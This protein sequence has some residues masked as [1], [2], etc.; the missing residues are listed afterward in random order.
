M[1]STTTAK[2]KA[3]MTE[4]ELRA[5]EE[6][7]FANGP[8]SVLTQSVKNNTQILISCR[9]NRKLLA[10]V[11]ALC[12]V[13]PSLFPST[14]H[15][16]PPIPAKLMSSAIPFMQMWTE[17]PKAGKGK[18]KSKPINKDR[19]I[20]KLFLRGD[21]DFPFNS[22]VMNSARILVAAAAAASVLLADARVPSRR[23][24]STDAVIQ[25][26]ATMPTCVQT[27]LTAYLNGATLD[28]AIV[29]TLCVAV[30][31]TSS[32]LYVSVDNCVSS[33]S[34]CD[35][36]AAINVFTQ[37][38]M[39]ECEAVVANIPTTTD[40]ATADTA[41]AATTDASTT[42]A[43]TTD[44]LTTDASATSAVATDA[45]S[46]IAKTTTVTTAAT[47]TTV[48]KT[49]SA[50]VASTTTTSNA[51]KTVVGLLLSVVGLVL[52]A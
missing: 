40:A 8:L 5:L 26:F 16:I 36:V 7:E 44:A 15:T 22:E 2:P 39:P 21:S 42:D 4:E 20:S 43:S 49:T 12:A 27:C 38:L 17:T 10:R 9:N 1:A 11:K 46:V 3:E 52:V 34:D 33:A 47:T 30:E 14:H 25:S 23:D 32:D 48:N 24:A 51:G 18:K 19:F 28:E 41:T 50:A 45:T 35:L 13:T 6:E 37:T 29:R 31:S